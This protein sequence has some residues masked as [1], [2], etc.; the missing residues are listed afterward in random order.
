MSILTIILISL[1]ILAFIFAMIKINISYW[2]GL[3]NGEFN[4]EEDDEE[5]RIW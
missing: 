3:K 1:V 2:K 5:N 4:K